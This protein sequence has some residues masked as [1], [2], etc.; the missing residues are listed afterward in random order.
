MHVSWPDTL[1]ALAVIVVMYADY[2]DEI[3]VGEAIQ[4][5]AEQVGRQGRET[6]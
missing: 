6:E 1:R 5:S 3:D 4:L 2:D